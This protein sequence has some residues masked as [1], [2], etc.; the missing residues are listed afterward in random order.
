MF[1]PQVGAF[2]GGRGISTISQKPMQIK[3]LDKVAFVAHGLL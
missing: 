1:S 3:A 2:V